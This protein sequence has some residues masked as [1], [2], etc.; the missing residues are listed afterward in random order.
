MTLS[1]E[2]RSLLQAA[3]LDED[4]IRAQVQ[5]ALDEDL[6]YGPDVTT[7]ATVPAEP[8]SSGPLRRSASG[9]SL[10]GYRSFQSSLIWSSV[11]ERWA[12]VHTG[13]TETTSMREE[14]HLRWRRRRGS[15]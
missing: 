8:A 9:R 11:A 6:A 10:R 13:R 14:S 1:G 2:T 3:R 12:R 4:A 7:Q 5:G 15:C